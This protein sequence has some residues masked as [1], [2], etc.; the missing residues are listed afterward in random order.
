MRRA[1]N[2]FFQT[3][4]NKLKTVI[5]LESQRRSDF[6]NTMKIILPILTMI[7]TMLTISAQT[8]P[9]LET[10]VSQNLAKWRAANYS[11]VR[12]KLNITLEKGAPLMKGTIEVSVKLT[13]TGAKNDLILDWRTTQ[14]ANDKD[15]PL[16]NVVAVNEMT[17]AQASRLHRRESGE[18]ALFI[19]SSL[20][21]SK[22]Y[23]R[24]PAQAGEPLALQSNEHL[25]IPQKFLK[26]GEN[27]IKINFASPI[28]TSGAAVTRYVDKED[29]AE[30][31]YS[32]FVPSDASTAFPVFDQPDLKARF[33]LNVRPPQNWRVVS[34][35][36]SYKAKMD[37]MDSGIVIFEETKPISTY[38]FAFAAGEFKG[39]NE[40]EDEKAVDKI[41][42]EFKSSKSNDWLSYQKSIRSVTGNRVYVRKSQA[43]KFKKE[44]A[45]VFRLNREGVKFLETYF[46][47]K[48]PFPK[49]DLVLIPEF[50]FGGMEHAGATFLRE[51]RVI[52][53]T[54]PTKNDYITRAN[55]IFHEAAHQWFGDTVTMK[56]FDDLWLKEGFAE[57]MAYKT[58]A[59]VMPEYN[60]WKIF[61]ERNKQAA[62]LTDVTRGT[63]PI[64]QEIPN[65][66]SAKSAYGNIV[67]RKAPSFLRQAEFFLGEDKFQTA[68][69]AFLKKHEFANAEWTDLVKEFETASKQDLKDWANVWVKQ[70]GLSRIVVSPSDKP[71]YNCREKKFLNQTNNLGDNSF[72]KMRLKTLILFE[73]TR[74]LL[75]GVQDDKSVQEIEITNGEKI[76]Y[77]RDICLNRIDPIPKFIFPNYQDY[78]YGIFLLDEKS[79]AYVLENIGAE[80]DDFLRSMMWGS[81]WDSVRFYELAP[82]DYV[83]LVIKN[84]NTET[85]ES[86]IQ[87]LLGRVSTAMNYYLS[88]KQRD[89]FAPRLEKAIGEKMLGAN[90]PGQ[91]LTFYRAFLTIASTAKAAEVLKTLLKV[92]NEATPDEI[93]YFK[94]N[95]DQ[96]KG[97]FISISMPLLRTKDKFDIVT[98]LLI[99]GDKDAPQ[100]LAELEKTE[101]SDDAKRYVY[102]ARAGVATAENKLKY[103]KDF[104]E[105]KE[106]SESYIESAFNVWNTPKHADL[107]LPYLEKALAE[108]PNLKK[109]RKIFFVNGWL[110]AFI[111]GQ[112][113]AEA[114][115]IVNKFLADNPN[116]DKDLRLKILENSDNLERAVKIREKFGK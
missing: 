2:F 34:N 29:G 19:K 113:S 64:Y 66:S 89:E 52:F 10:G 95:L 53:P 67:Y 101:K 48:F 1:D 17:G 104:T 14:F 106:I 110:S 21:Q 55:V 84:I 30:Y 36:D 116:L 4:I 16:A 114:L 108:L 115:A 82:E 73:G 109:N 7:F 72:W 80:K 74:S 65:L 38:V 71:N 47:Y 100:L 102:A 8:M 5:K 76:I 27:V 57:F 94:E 39:F 40:R 111:G 86:T 99:L 31:V 70:R 92:N 41:W 45:E 46:D 51:D 25:I 24:S 81:L 83:K 20:P 85:D 69:R 44:A 6:S 61:Y 91:R 32:L 78:G 22:D 50:P 98:K 23:S 9:P 26:A 59:K 11:D 62:Y 103:W 15:K 97:Q 77:E 63:T 107:T 49:Y 90:T 28:K 60:A 18:T 79:R 88:D 43:E 33:Q 58:L 96:N 12:Y 112:K 93:E 56:W 105:N 75:P 37:P 42:D 68:V 35:T 3:I 87:T 54:E 13:E